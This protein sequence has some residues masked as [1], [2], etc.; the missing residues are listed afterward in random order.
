MKYCIVGGEVMNI[1]V[2]G[3]DYKNAPVEIRE[4]LS[5]D[6]NQLEDAVKKLSEHKNILENVIVST[7]NRTE[8]YAVVDQAKP[9]RYFIKMFLSEWFGLDKDA[10][11][12]YLKI[13]EDDQAIEHLFRVVSG[14]DSMIIGETQ[15][16][17][18][19]KESF[20]LAQ[21]EQTTG[22]IFNHLFKQAITLGKRSHSETDIDG[23]AVSVSY[24]AVELAKK[25]F[26]H[27]TNKKVLIHGAGKMGEL[28]AKHLHSNGVEDVIVVNRTRAKAEE[29]TKRIGGQAYGSEQLEEALVHADILI[30][31]TGAQGYVITK[32]MVEKT[33]RARNGRPLFMVDIAVPRDLDPRLDELESIFLYDIDDLQGIV[34][35]NLE[36]RLKEATKIEA[37]IENELQEY[38]QWLNTLGVVPIIAALRDKALTIQEQTMNSI[39][40]KMPDLSE[41]EKKVLRKHTKSIVNQLLRDPI[42]QL[43]DMAVEPKAAE[44]LEMFT[45]LFAIEE[46][47]EKDEREAHFASLKD[48]WSEEKQMK[49]AAAVRNV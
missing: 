48:S 13:K 43:K 3:I 35:A 7:C 12:P 2:A 20:L 32:E 42:A 15:I 47:V 17:G 18:Q 11:E 24:A 45:K 14:L 4:K 36:E 40:R 37:M 46:Q 8:I 31:S 1:I 25:I 6:P 5:F 21:K 44:N 30:S 49:S 19:I 29:L 26:G 10:F 38:K 28:T 34:N 23:N 33:L 27:L 16:L 39:E 22:T 41:R 9:G